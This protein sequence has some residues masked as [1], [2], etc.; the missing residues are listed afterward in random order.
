[1]LIV[2]SCRYD[3]ALQNAAPL[4]KMGWFPCLDTKI[5]LCWSRVFPAIL[6]P[7]MR[8]NL[9]SSGEKRAARKIPAMQIPLD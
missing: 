2:G 7:A 9:H 6:T 8:Q 4:Q 3:M 1:M 5:R